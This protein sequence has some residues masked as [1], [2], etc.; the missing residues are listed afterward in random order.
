MPHHD[1][2]HHE[3]QGSRPPGFIA[4]APHQHAFVLLGS[5]T[6]FAV[7][8]T[9]YHHEEHKY[10]LVMK[11]ALPAEAK[12]RLDDLRA[13]FPADTFILSN[14][15]AE[16]D[17]FTIPDLPAG[18]R[19]S[20]NANVFQGLPAFS[21]EDEADPHFF[22]WDKARTI[23]VLADIDVT[24][25]R[26]VTFRPFAHHLRQP[27]YATY[28]L[29]G[30]G[31]EAHMT[32]LQTARLASGRFEAAMFGPDYD[33]VMSLRQA[34]DWLDK[35]LLEAGVVVSVP[36]LRLRD[37]TTGKPTTPCGPP[38]AD[39]QVLTVLYRGMGEGRSVVAG[40]TFLADTAVCNSEGMDV[41]PPEL[42]L[43]ISATPR[44]LMR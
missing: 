38:C 24:V 8:M 34:P 9:Q 41:C 12:S 7:H 5:E 22:P 43:T 23:P 40:T 18:R 16:S 32:N 19:R 28:L 39:G 42:S 31:E 15:D 21:P 36:A 44:E 6:I 13:R 17:L 33:H 2:S 10:Q 3:T 26:I 37:A 4:N 14:G 25:E 11:L 30:E 29:W 35:P 1:M 27:D 20:F